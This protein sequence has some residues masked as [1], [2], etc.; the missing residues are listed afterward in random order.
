[1]Y[2][3]IKQYTGILVGVILVAVGMNLFL[4]PNKIAAGGVSGAATIIY[5]VFN[6][7][8]GIVMLAMNVP[9]YIIGIWRLGFSFALNSLFGTIALSL[10]VDL[11]APHLPVPT[12]NL[13]LASIYGGVLN[14]IGLGIVFRN[15]STTGGTALAAAILRSYTGLNIGQLLFMVDAVVVA[16]AGLVFKSWEL[17]MYAM[18][19]IFIISKVIDVVQEG[20]TYAKG[21]IIITNNPQAVGEEIMKQL[22]RGATVW[23]AQGMYTGADRYVLLS[24]VHRSEV[25]KLKD[26]I[27]RADPRAFVITADVHEVIGEGFKQITVQQK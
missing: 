1:M 10:A 9:L 19:T 11:T 3:W 26:I 23:N 15:K 22:D 8:V 16:A 13:L 25:T 24:V 18:I 21:F 20:F 12:D 6:V 7:P 14:G 4:V 17:A 2:N 5:Y 27:Y